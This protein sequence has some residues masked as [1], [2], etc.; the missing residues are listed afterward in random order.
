MAFVACLAAVLLSAVAEP[1]LPAGRLVD[2]NGVKLWFESHDK[3][4][5]VVL[6]HGGVN[7]FETTFSKLV[8]SLASRYRVIGVEQVGHGHSPDVNRPYG[9]EQMADDTA[10]LLASQGVGP[11]DLV[12]FGDG[13]I[14]AFLDAPDRPAAPGIASVTDGRGS[15][16][17][18]IHGAWG[19]LRSFSRIVPVLSERSTVTRVSLR[20]HWPNPWPATEKEAYDGYLLENHAADVAKVIEKSGR[21]PVD[22]LG[23]SYGGVVAALLARSRP[24]LVRRLILVEPALYGILRGRPG[25]DKLVSDEVKWRDGLLARVRSGEDPLAIMRGMYDGSR[26]GTFD[27]FPEERRRILTA[28]ARTLG[29]VLTHSWVDF[30]F[31][32]EDAASLRMPVLLVEGEKT[33]AD[34][35]EIDTVLAGCLPDVRRDVLPNATH[36]I[37][38]DAPE[39]MARVVAEF[40]T[41]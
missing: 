33:D 5:P 34:M 25:G 35:R 39:A 27:S 41:R 17:F 37:Q 31:A 36:M 2:V 21:A 28:N 38:F 12:G 20:L 4:S 14:E 18:V 24:E 16:L 26:P 9:Y 29:P 3:G 40:V 15:P 32:C 23:H 1:S 22:L 30:P 19:D 11:A 8:P 6:L 13:G 7:T 10:A